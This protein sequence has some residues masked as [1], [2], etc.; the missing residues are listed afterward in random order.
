MKA[1]V[2]LKNKAWK[3]H[4]HIE[5]MAKLQSDGNMEHEFVFEKGEVSHEKE[6]DESTISALSG[7]EEIGPSSITKTYPMEKTVE[8]LQIFSPNITLVEPIQIIRKAAACKKGIVFLHQQ[9]KSPEPQLEPEPEPEAQL[10]PEPEPDADAEMTEE[11]L[12]PEPFLI[13][14]TEMKDPHEAAADKGGKSKGHTC[15]LC[16]KSYGCRQSLSNHKRLYHNERNTLQCNKC[17]K[18]F[19]SEIF[20]KNHMKTHVQGAV[21]K[22]NTCNKNFDLLA[23]LRRHQLTHAKNVCKDCGKT[24]TTKS[25]HKQNCTPKNASKIKR[26]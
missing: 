25:S 2:A 13:A 21:F 24:Y 19:A 22:C 6:E 17:D 7:D 18:V 14:K 10:E 16:G 1:T 3:N 20:L 8:R 9:Q 4:L 15:T 12:E 26:K 11:F 23:T 5:K